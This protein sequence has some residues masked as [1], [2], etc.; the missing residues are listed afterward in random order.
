MWDFVAGE[1]D[2]GEEEE[3]AV[4]RVAEGVFGAKERRFE[5]STGR[6]ELAMRCGREEREKEV[7]DVSTTQQVT[8]EREME[9]HDRSMLA[10]V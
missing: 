3:L 4:G 10:S 6:F 8:A 1:L 9:T 5:D 7:D 2:V